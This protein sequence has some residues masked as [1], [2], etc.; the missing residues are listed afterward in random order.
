[1]TPTSSGRSSNA[2]RSRTSTTLTTVMIQPEMVQPLVP[3]AIQK[4]HTSGARPPDL[5]AAPVCTVLRTAM[6]RCMDLPPTTREPARTMAATSSLLDASSRHKTCHT[7]RVQ[8][9][10]R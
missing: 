9:Y 6:N 7:C 3:V 1:M 10:G 5:C 8:S 2:A 4:C